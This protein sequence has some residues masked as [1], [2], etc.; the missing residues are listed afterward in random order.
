[1]FAG[2]LQ[3]GI[4]VHSLLHPYSILG[5]GTGIDRLVD[6]RW[7]TATT[8][9]CLWFPGSPFC[10]PPSYSHMH[11]KNWIMLKFSWSP[12]YKLFSLTSRD[13]YKRFHN[14]SLGLD[15]VITKNK[16]DFYFK[17][18]KFSTLTLQ[19]GSVPQNRCS[20]PNNL[21]THLRYLPTIYI[22]PI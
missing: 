2:I 14:S 6:G 18:F 9:L 8:Y 11:Y 21:S 3:L 7:S 17:Y 5:Q 10:K 15:A 1:M 20:K 22:T 4:L 19:I 13:C 16:I 12:A